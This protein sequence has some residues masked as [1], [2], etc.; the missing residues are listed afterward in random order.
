[1]EYAWGFRVSED[2]AKSQKQNKAKLEVESFN[3]SVLRNITL[4]LMSNDLLV[5]VG[6][7]GAG[8]TSLLY[9]IM[10]ETT[11]K[12]GKHAVRGTVAYVE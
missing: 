12:S 4:T 3:N 1:M 5:V 8:K 11:K 7:I 6:K 9:S 2:Q 10:D